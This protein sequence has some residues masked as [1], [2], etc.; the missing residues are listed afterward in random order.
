MKFNGLFK[1]RSGLLIGL[2]VAVA[3]PLLVVAATR[4]VRPLAKAVVH[5]C[6]GMAGKLKEFGAETMER[7]ADLRAEVEVERAGGWADGMASAAAGPAAATSGREPG[8][9]DPE[10]VT[11]KEIRAWLS[12]T[13]DTADVEALLEA[14]RS[15]KARKTAIEAIEARLSALTA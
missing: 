10:E 7:G 9:P 11:V 6:L 1:G 12:G 13:E 8:F 3:G 5:G 2:G 14:E 4:G 15:T